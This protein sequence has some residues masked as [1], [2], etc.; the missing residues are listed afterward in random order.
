MESP[1]PYD[2][3]FNPDETVSTY[4]WAYARVRSGERVLDVGCGNG[5]L[6]AKLRNDK[7]CSVSGLDREPHPHLRI[8]PEAF[9]AIDLETGLGQLEEEVR[10]FRPDVVLLMDVLEHLVEPERCL[11]TLAGSLS[12]NARLLISM[13]NAAGASIALRLLSDDFTYQPAGLLDRTHLRFFTLETVSR[14]LGECGFHVQ[15]SHGTRIPLPLQEW[16]APSSTADQEAFER[17]ASQWNRRALNYQLCLEAASGASESPPQKPKEFLDGRLSV[18]VR[19]HDKA[20]LRFLDAALFSLALQDYPDLE[21]IVSIQNPSAP[22]RTEVENLL[23]STPWR[24]SPRWHILPVEVAPATDGRARLLNQGIEAATGRYLAFLDDDDFI[25][26]H[27]YTT[28]IR[29]LR[30]RGRVAAVGG[31]RMSI[32]RL[33]GGSWYVEK[34][35]KPFAREE[36]ATAGQRR[37][38]LFGDNFVPI[39]SYVIDRAR[40]GAFELRFSENLNRLEDYEFLMRLAATFELDFVDHAIPVAEYRVRRD[41]SNTVLTEEELGPAEAATRKPWVEANKR[42]DGLRAQL[43]C[44]LPVSDLAAHRRVLLRALAEQRQAKDL[45]DQARSLRSSDAFRVLNFL[46]TQLNRHPRFSRFIRTAARPFLRLLRRLIRRFAP[47][48]ESAS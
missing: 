30:E 1:A 19:F 11:R 46:A 37:I 48:P 41:G 22:L 17:L 14:L 24:F 23:Q 12:G 45:M 6:L 26:H 36:G 32:E 28:L 9:H 39:H 44:L 18:V 38:D 42:I 43:V 47:H 40:L 25:Y 29:G 15:S 3:E 5:G 8:P 2:F 20:R 34:K 4:G 21:V 16:V 27:G 35:T 10:R 13:P 7:N 33:E 31:V